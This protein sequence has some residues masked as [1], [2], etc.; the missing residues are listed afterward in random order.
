MRRMNRYEYNNAVRDLLQLKG[1]VY[2]LPEKVIRSSSYFNPSS[3]SFPNSIRLSNRALG[4]NQIE[5]HILTGVSPFAIDLQSE[6]GFNN[7]GD[8]L[9]VSPIMVESFLNLG[10]SIVNAP[11]FD[12][13]S[14]LTN[15]GFFTLP[16]QVPLTRDHLED[17]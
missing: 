7:R 3:G 9:S 4:K 14:N 5:Q 10:R 6:H 17:H 15:S 13:Y 8:E 11:E 1:D 2:P 16:G 12:G